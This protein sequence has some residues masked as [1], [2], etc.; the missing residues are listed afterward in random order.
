[1][2][3]YMNKL[4]MGSLAGVTLLVASCADDYLNTKPTDSVGASSTF[5]TT[6]NAAMVIN[7]IAQIM[8]TQQYSF[9]QGYCGENRIKS[10]Y[11]EY[12]GKD[13][14]YNQM[15]PGWAV[16][17]NGD[18]FTRKATVY[19][20]YPWYYYYTIIGNANAVIVNIDGA[21]GTEEERA[22]IKAQ[23]LTFR[24][25]AYH[26][27]MQLYTYRWQDTNGGT[28]NGVVLR[29]DE[30]TGDMPLS[31][32]KDCYDQIYTDCKDA[33]ALYK[34]S[35]LN[36]NA[37]H[38]WL[39]DLSMAYAVYARA[40]LTRQDYQAALDN[41]KLARANHP[42]MTNDEYA[43]GFCKPNR[44]WILGSYGDPTENQ[45]YWTFGTQFACNGYY[46]GNTQ[47]GAGAIDKE[48]T[49][50]IPDND[51]RKA[52]FLT[53]D[54]VAGFDLTDPGVMSQ[55]QAYFVGDDIWDKAS[56]Y[57]LSKTP[58]GLDDAYQAGYFYL[59]AQLKFW[60]FDTPGISYLCHIRS[61][62]M[63]LIEAEANY[64]LQDPAKAQ[65]ALEELN[66]GSGRN[67]AYTCTKTGDGL[68]QEI[69]DYRGLELWG[70]GFSWFDYKRWNRD[71]TRKSIA[72]GGNVHVATAVTIKANEKNRWTWDIPEA[73]TN[74]NGGIDIAAN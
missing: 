50:K 57:I 5:E 43:A 40:A 24:A 8:T 48:L 15:A 70:E 20:A 28:T 62:E 2:K 3:K 14:V 9:S 63:V 11:G 10:I 42:L 39:P 36:R 71:I 32:V 60:V 55:T 22:F 73:E 56:E 69:I 27:L 18:Y 16:I 51:T 29:L 7:G 38:V 72:D 26:M 19:S 65:A 12:M 67:P 68:L 46:A 45:W 6:T 4:F 44:E 64:F 17:M 74:Y 53:V 30:T 52:L 25:Y 47:Y 23:A 59:G 1:M 33:I 58:S 37:S 34:S 49:D 66:A 61:S 54:K 31:P 21:E 41:A 35:G 13:F